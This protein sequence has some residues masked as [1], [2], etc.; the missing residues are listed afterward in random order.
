MTR[1]EAISILDDVDNGSKEVT[2]WEADFIDSVMKQSDD[3]F[4]SPSSRQAEVIAN[5]KAKYL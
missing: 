4:W 2:E 3:L 5:L 1:S